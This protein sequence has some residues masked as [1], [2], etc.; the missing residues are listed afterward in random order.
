MPSIS[1][2]PIYTDAWAKTKYEAM[3]TIVEPIPNFPDTTLLGVT[4][5]NYWVRFY[6]TE[7]NL[8]RWVQVSAIT[9]YT[10]EERILCALTAAT[11][12][13]A[14]SNQTTELSFTCPA[15][16]AQDS[17]GWIPLP[18]ISSDFFLTYFACQIAF[19]GSPQTGTYARLSLYRMASGTPTTAASEVYGATSTNLGATYHSLNY[20]ISGGY[21]IVDNYQYSFRIR[22]G[23]VTGVAGA[24]IGYAKT[25]R[26][27]RERTA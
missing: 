8:A 4:C 2:A 13:S 15:S 20:T 3:A 26:L 21:R 9:T 7:I 16:T 24:C 6:Y 10:D 14:L 18:D 27:Y 11:P 5:R 1:V 12:E 19:T 22:F 23:F 25:F 17:Y